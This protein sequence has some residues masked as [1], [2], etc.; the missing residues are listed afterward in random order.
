MTGTSLAFLDEDLEVA[1][2][3]HGQHWRPD[4]GQPSTP[5]YTRVNRAG[6]EHH[7]ARAHLPLPLTGELRMRS[8]QMI[9]E[10]LV[11]REEV[12]RKVTKR[13][14][15]RQERDTRVRRECGKSP[16]ERILLPQVRQRPAPARP[17]T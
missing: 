13:R 4:T 8:G 5:I 17:P 12:V 1:A 2:R 3:S 16:G 14:G 11:E 10:A 7:F 9:G 15:A 6:G